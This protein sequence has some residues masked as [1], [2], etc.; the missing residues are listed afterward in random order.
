MAE[1]GSGVLDLRAGIAA[2]CPRMNDKGGVDLQAVWSDVARIAEMIL[3]RFVAVRKLTFR[4]LN[5]GKGENTSGAISRTLGAITPCSFTRSRS[6]VF[7]T[8]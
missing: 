3:G 7:W 4:R 6:C 1:H 2:D 8:I 5:H